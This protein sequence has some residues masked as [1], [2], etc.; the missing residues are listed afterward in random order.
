MDISDWRDKIDEFDRKL[1]ELLNHRA[2]A[3][4]EIGK[5]K[6]Q[7]GMRIYEP[8][9]ERQV[10]QNIWD[11]NAGPLSE[12]DLVK[13]YERL[14]DVMRNVQKRII[15]PDAEPTRHDTEIDSQHED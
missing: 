12:Q 4:I 15:A 2:N 1:V 5:L 11:N 7:A 14:L 13:V 9:R 6:R 8:D 10:M 3:A